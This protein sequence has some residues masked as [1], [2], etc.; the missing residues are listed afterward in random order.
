MYNERHTTFRIRTEDFSL[1][2]QFTIS[3]IF[4]CLWQTLRRV[5]CNYNTIFN[6]E[7]PQWQ[8]LLSKSSISEIAFGLYNGTRRK[9]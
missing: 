2:N 5:P 4:I 3:V 7:F 6:A 1:F 8:C 9:I